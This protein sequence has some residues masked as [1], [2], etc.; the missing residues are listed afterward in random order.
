MINRRCKLESLLGSL[1]IRGEKEERVHI[2]EIETLILESTAVAL[3]AALVADL[4]EAGVNII[5]C[6]RKHLPVSVFLP[7]HAHF[8]AA[9]NIRE[10]I[11]WTDERKAQCRRLVIREKIRQQALHLAALGKGWDHDLLMAYHSEV[12]DGDRE[13]HEAHA[14]GAYFRALFGTR[15]SRDNAG[16]QNDALDYGYTL[17]MAAFAREISACGYLTELGIWHRGVEN[18]FNLAS[19]LMEPFRPAVDRLAT[20]LPNDGK[21]THKRYMLRL[22]YSRVKINGECQ[23]LV[24]AVR[25][26]LHRVFRFMRGEVDELFGLEIAAGEE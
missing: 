5:F 12:T 21:E 19:D 15:F 20:S 22:L 4:T 1:V 9:K 3:T 10:Q 14:A 18:A 2:S 8:S 25:I 24:P 13:N 6:D 26:H 16:F 23:S 11:A 7:V 17:L